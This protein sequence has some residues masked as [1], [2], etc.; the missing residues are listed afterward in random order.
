MRRSPALAGRILAAVLPLALATTAPG[1]AE[2]SFHPIRTVV[3]GGEGGWDYV[4]F[5]GPGHR[6]FVTRSTHVMV[7]DSDRLDVIGD[8]PD[9]PGVHGVA[10]ASGTGHGFTSN[11]RDTSVTMFDA[12]TLA[13]LARIRVGLRPDAITYDAASKRVFVMDAGSAECTAVDP[14]AGAAIGTVALGGQPEEAVTDGRGRIYVNLADTREVVTVDTQ[15]LQVV[16]RWS[17]APGE[18]PTGIAL[19]AEH[20]RLFSGCSNG[21]LV[22]SDVAKG[23]VVATLPIGARVD[24]VGFDPG[25]AL[26][27]SSNGEGTLSI[28]HEDSPGRFHKVGDLPT[29]P[30]ARTLAFDPAR[31]RV[32]LVTARFG[33]PPEPTAEQPRPRAPMVP[34]SFE[35]LVLGE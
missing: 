13:K 7:L 28:V 14:V 25:A 23:A 22:V 26:A 15:T 20:G 9:T 32:F 10:L 34:G 5:D 29:A 6:L 30:G 33:T 21:K 2:R 1:A 17:L 35:L 31:H 16:G 24:G 4:L 12:K 18:G 8:I 11:G 19:D 3:L 27:F